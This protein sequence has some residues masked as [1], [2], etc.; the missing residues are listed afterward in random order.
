M[1]NVHPSLETLARWLAGELEHEEVLREVAP[2]LV[3]SCPVCQ[4]LR[5]E[6]RRLQAES[7]H[8]NEV[9]AVLETREA[10]ALAAALEERTHEERMR[11]AAEDEAL[12]TWGL[13]R[14][15]LRASREAIF[16]DPAHAVDL[17]RLAVRL[18]AHLS[19]AYHSDWIRDLR[20]RAYAQLGNAQR[21][22]GELKGAEH[23]SLRAEEC[24]DASGTG[25][26][27]LRA[28][29]FGLKASLRLDQRRFEEAGDLL[30]RSLALFREVKDV[31]GAAKALL[32]KARLLYVQEDFQQ[33]ISLLRQS[34]PEIEQ[35]GD[36]HLSART[37]QN[38]LTYLTLAGRHEE[39]DQ[40]LPELRSLFRDIAEPLD[41]IK[42]RWAEASIAQGLGRPAEAETLYREVRSDFLS[43]EKG[44]DAA[45]VSLDLAALLAEQGRFAELKPL[46]AEIVAAFGARGVDRE[47]LASLLLFQQACT[48]ERVTLEM[49][50]G[51]AVDLR[52]SRPGLRRGETLQM[53]SGSSE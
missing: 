50:R 18:S 49:I 48:E 20:A 16:Q 8:W 6:I 34:E 7:G 31:H 26:L 37:R 13:C 25:D 39:A 40:L 15:F 45:L 17:A 47:A 33:A 5:D 11:L 51:L 28:E 53:S 2:H 22:L 46:A 3:A 27:S 41:W 38:L 35:A 52:R 24:L 32:K 4:R 14:Y 21:V 43:L 12:H 1:D 42:L 10:P 23:A 19:E 30:D 9:V 29:V 44:Y 36:I